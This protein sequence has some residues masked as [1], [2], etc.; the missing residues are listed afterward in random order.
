MVSL[1][2]QLDVARAHKH[3][4]VEGGWEDDVGGISG[5]VAAAIMASKVFKGGLKCQFAVK[6][7]P[8]YD[9]PWWGLLLGLFFF[10]FSL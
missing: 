7:N 5:Q 4:E 9:G 2:G 8:S 6:V 1:V 10:Y 3:H